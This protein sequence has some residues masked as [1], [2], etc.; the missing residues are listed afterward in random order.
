MASNGNL[1]QSDLAPIAAGQLAKEAAAAWNA[2]NVDSRKRFGVELR[3][4][5]RAIALLTMGSSSMATLPPPPRSG[6]T[7]AETSG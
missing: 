6:F 4:T 1:P 3:P 2:M 5:G 7:L